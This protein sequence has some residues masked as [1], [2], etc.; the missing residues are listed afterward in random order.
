[1]NVTTICGVW[2]VYFDQTWGHQ[3][4]PAN[5]NS[6]THFIYNYITSMINPEIYL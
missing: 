3:C 2:N 5:L 4:I 6:L 1:M